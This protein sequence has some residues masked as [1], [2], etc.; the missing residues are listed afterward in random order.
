MN[1]IHK[2]VLVEVKQDEMIEKAL[3]VSFNLGYVLTLLVINDVVNNRHI[4]YIEILKDPI[5]YIILISGIGIALTIDRTDPQVVIKKTGKYLA[6]SFFAAI[7]LSALV[8]A[9]KVEL[10]V[11]W[12]MFYSMIA[13]S[14]TLAP[15]IVRRS[16]ENLPDVVVQGIL[17]A[18]SS[19]FKWGANKYTNTNDNPKE[20]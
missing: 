13:I 12:F 11:G 6:Y 19:F 5:F 17:S 8:V 2:I 14:T 20:K 9:A 4:G 15:V 7:C 16:L 18:V 3:N 1:I 10:E